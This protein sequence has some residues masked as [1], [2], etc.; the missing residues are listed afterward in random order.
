MAFLGI[1]SIANAQSDCSKYLTQNSG[2][3]S[4]VIPDDCDCNSCDYGGGL[5]EYMKCKCE[6]EKKSR[7]Q[8]NW[9]E[10]QIKENRTKLNE[11]NNQFNQLYKEAN[12]IH[13]KL[14]RKKDISD[15]DS[16]KSKAL[17]LYQQ[18]ISK[19]KEYQNQTV[20]HINTIEKR[21][22][23][24][25]QDIVRRGKEK[26]D[27]TQSE[28]DDLKNVKPT[29]SAKITLG[30]NSSGVG[31][32][33]ETNNN[34]NTY[35]ETEAER[36]DR[37]DREN[38]Q[39]IKQETQDKIDNLNDTYDKASEQLGSLLSDG[40]Q[41]NDFYTLSRTF[42]DAGLKTEALSSVA[43]GTAVNIGSA[44][45]K[46]LKQAKEEKILVKVALIEDYC[47]DIS[48]ENE[49]F[50]SLL[51]TD[52]YDAL[53]ESHK[54]LL[55]LEIYT[56]IELYK[57]KYKYNRDVNSVDTKIKKQQKQRTQAVLSINTA[58]LKKKALDD[59]EYLGS[60]YWDLVYNEYKMHLNKDLIKN[61]QLGYYATP[62]WEL[63]YYND[64]KFIYELE[65]TLINERISIRLPL[66][67]E[68]YLDGKVSLGT[69]IAL[70]LLDPIDIN[71]PDGEFVY[72]SFF[73]FDKQSQI[74]V[75]EMIL[76]RGFKK[77]HNAQFVNF[78]FR[79]DG[80]KTQLDNIKTLLNNGYGLNY[81][82]SV[83]N[84]EKETIP[85]YEYI[86][87]F[88]KNEYKDFYV[89]K[90][91]NSDKKIIK[92]LSNYVKNDKKTNKKNVNT[93]FSERKDCATPNCSEIQYKL[94]HITEKE[95]MEF[96]NTNKN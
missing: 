29:V 13:S 60:Y 66:I 20:T 9:T 47:N 37:L 36:I 31:N 95:L 45:I 85:L 22:T 80:F 56:L 78:N 50:I 23:P 57:V 1:I 41:G 94:N 6:E 61:D 32:G 5:K 46:D 7:E 19:A 83:I 42:A 92:E 87:N 65:N 17:S 2:T 73:N 54:K 89:N 48:K 91:S 30:N 4:R 93:L 44:L 53:L 84:E 86:S 34:S 15:F 28:I 67:K 75:I 40:L 55:Q 26:I 8:Y 77:I 81:Y 16:Q 3:G 52:D 21:V 35:Q 96:L 74:A 24:V 33:Y 82:Y 69:Y 70:S 59:S 79:E 88:I 49:N 14:I 10:Q 12:A 43:L 38:A 58:L 11:I 90:L 72:N 25:N 68:L 62:I 64:H 27:M 18:A 63:F 71:T 51:K 76:K 39:R